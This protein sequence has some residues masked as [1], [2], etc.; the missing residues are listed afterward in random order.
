[1]LH[2]RGMA[3]R[4]EAAIQTKLRPPPLLG[5]HAIRPCLARTPAFSR[6]LRNV[7]SLTMIPR[8]LHRLL[9]SVVTLIGT[10]AITFLLM[11]CVPGDV[12]RVIAGAK[13]SP[14]VLQ[15]VHR[16]LHLDDPLPVR[17]LTYLGQLARGDL[18]YSYVTDQ[19]VA[20]AIASRIPT[21][22]VLALLAMVL[23][24]ALAIP[25][26]VFTATRR[27]SW[28]DRAVLVGATL[29][30][31]LPAFWLARM[32]QYWLSYRLGV[33]PV[34]GYRGFAH[35]LLPALTLAVLAAGYYTRLIHTSMVEV[36]DQPYVR[37]ARAKG[38]SES[39]VLIRYGLRNALVPVVTVLGM[40]IAYL[41]GGVVFVE[42]VFAL[43]GIGTLAVQ[44]VFNLDVAMILGVV[45]F[46]GT[47]VVS[48]NLL[49]DALYQWID[50]RVKSSN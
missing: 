37:A 44:S 23:W 42:N 4:I 18:G 39:A 47:C 28:P 15:E 9:G 10:A 1:M 25:V 40:D 45:L 20:D 46:S 38:L 35:L 31:S 17:L 19:P 12:A 29:T 43:P 48:T 50:P 33:F 27:G 13:A 24:M 49:V 32:A 30:L 14:E 26:G 41:L 5:R 16:K 8:L 11:N 34:A 36:L 7:P 21:T 2:P 6:V 3:L 22:A